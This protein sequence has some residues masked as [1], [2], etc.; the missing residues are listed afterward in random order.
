MAQTAPYPGDGEASEPVPVL[1]VR[2]LTLRFGGVHALRSV[3][4]DVGDRTICGLVGPNGAGKT[5][6]FN[7]VS[8]I[9]RPSSGSIRVLGTDVLATAPHKLV[10]LGVARTF[11]HA[12]LPA[13][14]T[15]LD[16]VLV[17]AHSHLSSG[18]LSYALRLP[19]ALSA[20]RRLRR[21]A[22]E[23]LDYLGLDGMAAARTDALPHA[24]R[25]RV[26]LARALMAR[27]RLLL[28]DEPASGLPHREVTEFAALISDIRDQYGV[29]VLLVEHHMGLI[30]R[31]SDH[32]IALVEGSKV[33]EGPPAEVQTHPVVVEAYLGSSR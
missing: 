16:S 6:L 2:R 25:K 30:S 18:P 10:S 9:Y 28:L 8:G 24:A 5:S 1:E 31:V 26:E 15:V 12:A 4:I 32:V 20:E 22:R 21:R 27:P 3:D 17:G 7:C 23:I 33:A 11:Q 19:G 14:L 13:D 29:T